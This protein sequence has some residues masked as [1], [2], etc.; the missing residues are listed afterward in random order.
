MTWGH[1]DARTRVVLVGL[2]LVGLL[3][4]AV[5]ARRRGWARVALAV[6][7][8]LITAAYLLWRAEFTG[9]FQPWPDA[10]AWGILLGAECFGFF[11]QVVFLL[12]MAPAYRRTV[13]DWPTDR[14]LPTVDVFVTTAN[15]PLTVLRRTLIACRQIDYPADRVAVYVLDDGARPE[16]KAFAEGLGLR[17]VARSTHEHAKAGNLNHGLEVS[18]GEL[19]LTLDADMVP[20]SNILRRMIGDFATPGTGFA[21]APQAF[22]N[23]DPFQFNLGVH[24]H[25][26][27]E[28]D[29]FMRY[30]LRAR[31]RVGAVMYVGSNA[32]FSRAA[33]RELGGFSTGSVTEDV[34]TG[35]LLEAR[36][37]RGTF[38]DEVLA[39]GLA[40]ESFAEMVPQRVRWCRGSLQTARLANPL[41]LPGLTPAQRVQYL[42][43]LLY[44][45]GSLQKLVYLLM[46]VLYLDFG[47]AALHATLSGILTFWLPSFVSGM[48]A[49]G[50]V[51]GGRRTFFWSHLY[52]I[53]FMP[54]LSRAVLAE[55][56][57]G[58]AP[59]FHVTRKGLR[60]DGFHVVGAVFWPLA[61]LGACTLIGL[62]RALPDLLAGPPYRGYPVAHVGPAA[63]AIN[64]FWAVSNLGGIAL[65][66]LA[67][68]DRP[69]RRT[70]ERFPLRLPALIDGGSWRIAGETRDV[71]EGGALVVLPEVPPHITGSVRVLLGQRWRDAAGGGS[72]GAPGAA[73]IA[74]AVAAEVVYQESERNGVAVGL[75]FVHLALAQEARILQLLFDRPE[76]IEPSPIASAPGWLRAVFRTWA[77]ITPHPRRRRE[78]RV[79]SR[80]PVTMRFS[81]DASTSGSA[82]A[83][84]GVGR[85]GADVA[86]PWIHGECLDVSWGGLLVRVPRR[87]LRGASPPPSGVSVAVRWPASGGLVRLD[88]TGVRFERQARWVAC[89]LRWA[90]P[91]RA[92][93]VIHDVLASKAGR[94]TAG[95]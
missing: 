63:V 45:F 9:V 16:V 74:L 78:A 50:A 2:E 1:L 13:P 48:L 76:A 44:W 57:G 59:H 33:L 61:A 31:D 42:S 70:G 65:A 19:V 94:V 35:M 55:A 62:G 90:D 29:F 56:F 25:L 21:Q 69:R 38:V 6:A 54:V 5:L 8:I 80:I 36:G 34:L 43:G 3:V 26:P 28:Q 51:A 47:I 77:A 72:P 22:F 88:A 66:V 18:D 15:E 82:G 85:D 7:E 12:T 20:K 75:R 73:G 11:Q 83:S 4:L 41:T 23:A 93:P 49:F 87:A 64:V 95:G 10:V 67:S 46:P 24:R 53:A 37:F 86:E 60:R 58:R 30:Q 91:N 92:A 89:H 52:D 32:L 71:G 79:R 81:R 84:A 17:Y 39:V 27:G 40:A 14:P 68:V